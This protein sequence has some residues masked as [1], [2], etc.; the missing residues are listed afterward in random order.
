MVSNLE[1]AQIKST[2]STIDRGL[3]TTKLLTARVQLALRRKQHVFEEKAIRE[4]H[5][6][7]CKSGTYTT[8][9]GV[10]T[11]EVHASYPT[12]KNGFR[13]LILVE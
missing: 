3:C 10:N 12:S 7:D 9:M 2:T 6:V 11:T 4:Y 1:E 8:V 13:I 5:L